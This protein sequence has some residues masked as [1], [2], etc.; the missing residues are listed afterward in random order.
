MKVPLLNFVGGP[1]V[2][3]LNS[4]G[5]PGV[6]L[7]NFSGVPGPTFKLWGGPGSRVPGSLGPVPTFTQCLLLSFTLFRQSI[8]YKY[9]ISIISSSHLEVFLRKGVLQ[10]CSNFSG[11]HL[12]RSA[13]CNFIALQLY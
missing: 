5:G 11:E 9:L 2:P 12:C 10:I 1:E 7:L 8:F 6:P 4:E 3:V 13:I